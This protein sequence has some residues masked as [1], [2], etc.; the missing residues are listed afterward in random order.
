MVEFLHLHH[1]V[2][3]LLNILVDHLKAQGDALTLLGF[4]PLVDLAEVVLAG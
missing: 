3:L 4:R 2:L 1:S